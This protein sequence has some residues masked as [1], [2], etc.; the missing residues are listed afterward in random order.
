MN[1][2]MYDYID[3]VAPDVDITL[4]AAPYEIHP[5]GVVAERGEKNQVIHT[6]D[7][8]SEERISFSNSSHFIVTLSWEI[9]T[10]SE[11]GTLI[12]FYYDVAKGNGTYN[13]FKWAHPDDGHIY[14]LRFDC[15]MER[16]RK[17]HDIYGILNIKFKILG[18]I[19]D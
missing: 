18:R 10:E 19:A 12:D 9:I 2:E 11:S 13:S 3:I 8:L 17:A 7:D 1:K 15:S 4:G 6:G 5:Q 14:V 16:A